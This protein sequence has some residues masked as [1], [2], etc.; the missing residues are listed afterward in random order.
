[1]RIG[2]FTDLHLGLRQYGLEEREED[3]YCQYFKAIDTFV[4]QNVDIVICAG[5]IFD[6]ARPSPRALKIFSKGIQELSKNSIDFY[7][8][9]GNH[10]MVQAKNFVTADN[11]LQTISDARYFLLDKDFYFEND[12]IFLCG[13]PY[14]H[15][16]QILDFVEEVDLLNDKAKDKKGLKVLV[17]H[18]AFKEYCGFTGEKLSINDINI[19]NFDLIICGHIHDTK[20]IEVRLDSVCIQGDSIKRNNTIYLQ[21]GSIERSSVAE[22]RDEENYGKGVFIIDTDNFSMENI[23]NGFISLKSP[24][25]FLIADMYIDKKEDVLDIKKEILKSAK[26][27]SIPPILFLT[28]HDVSESFQSLIDLTKELKKD[29]L[30]VHFNYFDESNKNEFNILN[31]TD[32]PSP[33][34]ALKIALNPLDEDEA[35]LGLDLY[36]NL[37]D[38]KDISGILKEFADKRSKRDDHK[39]NYVDA[40]SL[41]QEEIKKF[42]EYFEKI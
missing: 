21:P 24:R 39:D 4:E 12:D 16:Y 26:N 5:D 31:V 35:R 7:N 38:D 10:S 30:T 33:R 1:M 17:L 9:V 18:Q 19:S 23:S 28:V 36:D 14:Y 20:I 13:L 8:I 37:K 32:I 6:Q 29:C 22:A 40:I 27:C 41:S 3:F 42:E 15:N 11:L 25:K 2:V 34:E